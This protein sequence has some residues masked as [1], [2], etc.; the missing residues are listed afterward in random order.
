MPQKRRDEWDKDIREGDFITCAQDAVEHG[1]K[2]DVVVMNPT[3]AEGRAALHVE[4]ACSLLAPGGRLVAVMPGSYRNR[5]IIP[6]VEAEFSRIY[7]SDFTTTSVSV[8]LMRM[9][10]PAERDVGH[11][12]DIGIEAVT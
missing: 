8:V 3:F 9:T 4:Y 12:F 7:E 11:E 10:R 5:Q 1:R 6:N 2:F